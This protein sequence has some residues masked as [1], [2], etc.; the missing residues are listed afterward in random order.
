M[1]S[2]HWTVVSKTKP[3]TLIPRGGGG[4]Y[5]PNLVTF[6]LCIYLINVVSKTECNAGNVSLLLNLINNNFWFFSREASHF[7]SLLAS[8]IRTILKICDPILATLLKMRPHYIVREYPPPR[9]LIQLTCKLDLAVLPKVIKY[10]APLIP[11]FGQWKLVW[12]VF[13]ELILRK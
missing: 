12:C 1:W 10:S 5:D 7:E 4:G 2:G 9:P 13:L 11:Y 8:K 6:Y 3:A